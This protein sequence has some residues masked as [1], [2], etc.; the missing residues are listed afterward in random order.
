MPTKMIR[1]VQATRRV[2]VWDVERLRKFYR[3]KEDQ[4]PFLQSIMFSGDTDARSWVAEID[5]VIQSEAVKVLISQGIWP[6]VDHDNQFFGA[7]SGELTPQ[8]T[9]VNMAIRQQ[10]VIDL[11]P[12]DWNGLF[13][14]Y[15]LPITGQFRPDTRLLK[16]LA[17]RRRMDRWDTDAPGDSFFKMGKLRRM[18]DAEPG[19]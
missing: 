2:L 7:I 15:F 18:G 17:D 19:T 12:N 6:D 4:I 14:F 13:T 1:T 3:L 5:G 10:L 16:R 11:G 9:P 8:L